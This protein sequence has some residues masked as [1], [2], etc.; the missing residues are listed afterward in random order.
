MVKGSVFFGGA[1]DKVSSG[2]VASDLFADS[3][4][5]DIRGDGGEIGGVNVMFSR[6]PRLSFCSGVSTGS[7][8]DSCVVHACCGGGENR[9]VLL[10]IGG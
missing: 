7:R 3:P 1:V 5:W 10:C 2:R 9:F 4:K 6:L 8:G